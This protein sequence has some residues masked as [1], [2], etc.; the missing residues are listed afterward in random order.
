M[1]T[2]VF[3]G[4]WT[5]TS[6]PIMSTH[7]HWMPLTMAAHPNQVPLLS[8]SGWRMKWMKQSILSLRNR[9]SMSRSFAQRAP[10]YTLSKHL[11]QMVGRQALR[12]NV[13]RNAD[14]TTWLGALLR[15]PV[16]I[17]TIVGGLWSVVELVNLKREKI[18]LFQSACSVDMMK[19]MAW[20][21]PVVCWL[22]QKR[23]AAGHSKK[24]GFC[25]A[26]S[27]SCKHTF[28]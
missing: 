2:A 22:Q 12:L 28:V 1:R 17:N 5:M 23:K 9:S 25:V 27:V 6:C 10:S 16:I 13:S 4:H 18:I 24:S 21:I 7:L 19:I 15:I 3:A 20:Q 11:I 26:T 14:A 8:R